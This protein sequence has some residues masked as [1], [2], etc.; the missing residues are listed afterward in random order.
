MGHFPRRRFPLFGRLRREHVR[1][2]DLD[3]AMC[4]HG[5]PV[6]VAYCLFWLHSVWAVGVFF[7]PHDAVDAYHVFPYFSLGIWEGAAAATALVLRH[8]MRTADLRWIQ[9]GGSMGFFI[10]AWADLAF[11]VTQGVGTAFVYTALAAM[12]GWLVY[13]TRYAWID[14]SSQPSSAPPARERPPTAER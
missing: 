7:A 3:R 2:L 5:D 1:G 9:I 13:L 12:S 4:K 6:T 10:W 14:T 11:L 8:G